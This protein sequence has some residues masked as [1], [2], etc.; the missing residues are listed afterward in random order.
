MHVK[1]QELPMHDPRGK[2]GLGVGYAT[3]PT[4]ADHMH[5]MH[6]TDFA[7]VN[8]TMRALGIQEAVDPNELSPA[9]L[10]IFRYLVNWQHFKNCGVYCMFLPYDPNRMSE[11]VNAVTGW[12]TSVFEL[13]KVGER[14]LA[15]MRTFNAR[16]GLTAADDCLPER[17][18]SGVSTGPRAGLGINKPAMQEAIQTYYAMNGW[19]STSGAPTAAKLAELD[20]AWAASA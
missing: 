1:G 4:G 13:M 2:V 10:R 8:S 12:N 19:D 20:V 16:E 6:D 7:R 14:A 11:L 5:N 9:K 15:L 17:L 18:Y 3:S